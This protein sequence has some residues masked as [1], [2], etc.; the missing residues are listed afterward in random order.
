MTNIDL[1]HFAL[2]VENKKF[3]YNLKMAHVNI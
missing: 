3:Q 2:G 1:P